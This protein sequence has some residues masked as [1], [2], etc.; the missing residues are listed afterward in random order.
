MVDKFLSLNRR[1]LILVGPKGSGK[2]ALA[3]LIMQ[4]LLERRSP[5]EAVPVFLSL[6]SWN[7]AE[8]LSHW[9]LERVTSEYIGSKMQGARE[10]TVERLIRND[11]IIPILDGLDELPDTL[12]SRALD[13]INAAFPTDALILTC[14][15]QEYEALVAAHGMLRGAAVSTAAPVTPQALAT[16]LRERPE[17]SAEKWDHIIAAALESPDSLIARALTSPLAVSLLAS[18]YA[19]PTT[20]PDELFDET[21]FSTVEGIQ[22]HLFARLLS[23]YEI[24]MQQQPTGHSWPERRA[25][26]WLGNFARHLRR[27]GTYDLTLWQLSQAVNRRQRVLVGGLSG[28]TGAIVADTVGAGIVGLALGL[29][30]G[31]TF[32]AFASLARKKVGPRTRLPMTRG[33]SGS[34]FIRGNGPLHT[35]AFGFFFGLVTALA[36]DR[37][38]HRI[39]HPV[40]LL[41]GA[42]PATILGLLIGYQGWQPPAV[43]F[44]KVGTTKSLRDQLAQ[45]RR[46]NLIFLVVVCGAAAIAKI[47]LGWL[48]GGLLVGVPLGCSASFVIDYLNM[49]WWSFTISRCLL[50]SEDIFPWRVI[51]FIE[52]TYDYEIFRRVGGVY[53]FRH[54]ELQDYLANEDSRLYAFE[55]GEVDRIL[56]GFGR[57]GQVTPPAWSNTRSR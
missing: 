27:S 13:A 18:V 31:L 8:S 19:D 22:G 36:L 6:S 21:R 14:R 16:Y 46:R 10:A 38:V 25:L 49:G 32:G 48:Y 41:M 24:H 4:E 53:Q 52:D 47:L 26:R 34:S 40:I 5:T 54:A 42:L 45:E 9:I 23:T 37:N 30:I 7:P 51:T 3:I 15:H 20:H 2:S 1:R 50:A 28:L 56:G 17:S 33:I 43:L 35:L 29:G 55:W 11:L 12:R 57:D 44:T 39:S